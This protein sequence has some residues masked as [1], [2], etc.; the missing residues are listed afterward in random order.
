MRDIAPVF[1]PERNGPV[2]AGYAG[3]HGVLMRFPKSQK[4]FDG[5]WVVL[6]VRIHLQSMSESVG[7]GAPWALH[8]H[9]V[10]TVPARWKGGLPDIWARRS[11]ARWSDS[12]YRHP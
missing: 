12:H 6:T 7:V 3:V 1:P 2:I 9:G 10:N 11:S 4:G 5:Q 8:D